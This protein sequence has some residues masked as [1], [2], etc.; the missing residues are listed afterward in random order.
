MINWSLIIFFWPFFVRR[1]CDQGII[2]TWTKK[3]WK[4]IKHAWDFINY[5]HKPLDL[6]FSDSILFQGDVIRTRFS[7]HQERN[8]RRDLQTSAKRSEIVNVARILGIYL[9]ECYLYWYVDTIR[10]SCETLACSE[11]R[12]WRNCVC[13][14]DNGIFKPL[15]LSPISRWLLWLLCFANWRSYISIRL[16]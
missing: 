8:E 10:H 16:L 11:I 5:E 2:V 14:K 6:S 12:M 13:R 7:L 4:T 3:L 15:E 1:K 9:F